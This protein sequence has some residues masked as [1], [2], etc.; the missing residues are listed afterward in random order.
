M[1]TKKVNSHTSEALVYFSKIPF[2][3][4]FPKQMI[5]SGYAFTEEID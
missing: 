1:S 5:I 3:Y 4:F 2:V